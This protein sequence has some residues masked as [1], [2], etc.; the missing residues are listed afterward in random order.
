VTFAND[1]GVL[2]VT[3]TGRHGEEITYVGS[4]E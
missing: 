3:M 4:S 2:L 1:S